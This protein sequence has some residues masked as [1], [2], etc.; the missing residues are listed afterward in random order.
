VHCAE[1]HQLR[2]AVNEI[3]AGERR[4]DERADAIEGELKNVLGPISGEKSVNDLADRDELT[5][6]RIDV[7]ARVYTL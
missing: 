6:S 4:T 1:A 3:D 2:R 7:G 5:D